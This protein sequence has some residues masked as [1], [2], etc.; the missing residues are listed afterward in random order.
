MFRVTEPALV[1]TVNVLLH[2]DEPGVTPEKLPS[3]NSCIDP[4]SGSVT[5]PAQ[6]D[7]DP[8]PIGGIQAP[9]CGLLQ[10]FTVKD[11]SAVS[12]MPVTSIG[13]PVRLVIVIVYLNAAPL[14][15]GSALGALMTSI[16]PVVGVG[17]GTGVSVGVGTG[18]SVG[19]GTGVSV[20]VGTG[21]S[22]G[23]GG[24]V[25]VAVGARVAV[26]VGG[27]VA[28]AVGGRVAVAVGGRG[29]LV[30]S[31]GG[32]GVLV[33]RGVSVG[34]G[35]GVSVACVLSVGCGRGV[36]VAC[37]RG[38]FVGFDFSV[39]GVGGALV[40]VLVEFCDSLV[41]VGVAALVGRGEETT[42]APLSVGVLVAAL[43][44]VLVNPP[45]AI[46]GAVA[47][48]AGG[49]VPTPGSV[50]VGALATGGTI[51]S[52]A[53]GTAPTITGVAVPS[54]ATLVAVARSAAW[55]FDTSG[56]IPGSGR[57]I[58]QGA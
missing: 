20:G 7:G 49:T 3:M 34:C 25:K 21:V 52:S 24:G 48:G 50:G 29:V 41:L 37:G 2:T 31:G 26:A 13:A 47:V 35:R 17:V 16:V 51:A 56:P 23:V 5:E 28:V 32:L 55:A 15:V 38:V 33:G 53:V 22:V 46:T 27:R 18:V 11:R 39:V 54:K 10:V 1:V 9:P 45:P 19:V 40:G 14:V 58:S 30:L 8:V 6:I 43:V 57:S 4:L 44:G 42:V 36:S 12:W